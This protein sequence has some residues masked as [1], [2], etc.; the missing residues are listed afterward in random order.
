MGKGLGSRSKSWSHPSPGQQMTCRM[1]S[2]SI[3]G[4]PA[5]R[6]QE[7]GGSVG[8]TGGPPSRRNGDLEDTGC[9]DLEC[10]WGEAA[11]AQGSGDR[12]GYW[13]LLD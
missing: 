11:A 13:S 7:M 8:C 5:A 3:R 1:K 4:A 6:W 10:S 12:M 9:P 2:A